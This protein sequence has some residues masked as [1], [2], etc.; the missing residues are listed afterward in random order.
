MEDLVNF[1]FSVCGGIIEP[2]QLRSE[3]LNLMKILEAIRPKYVFEIGTSKGGTLF[4][5]LQ[6]VA[7]D[8]TILSIDLP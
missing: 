6:V 2:F 8:A 4:L 5:L 1:C 7:S 3:I